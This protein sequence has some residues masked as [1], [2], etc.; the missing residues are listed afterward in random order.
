MPNATDLP[1]P[2]AGTD[3]AEAAL[4]VKCTTWQVGGDDLGLQGPER[5]SLGDRD[6]TL[7]QSGADPLAV[8]RLADV[9]ADLSDPGCASGIG[10]S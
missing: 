4:G 8:R 2:F 1:Q 10:N 9:D 3:L 6:E 7:Q 5:L